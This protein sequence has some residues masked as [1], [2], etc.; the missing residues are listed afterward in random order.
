[1]HKFPKSW[2]KHETHHE[3]KVHPVCGSSFLAPEL[4]VNQ[5]LEDGAMQVL[6]NILIQNL[7]LFFGLPKHKRHSRN[8]DLRDFKTMSSGSVDF[9]TTSW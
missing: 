2:H 6:V 7:P 8:E 3:L 4:V 9:Y 1:M 5:S